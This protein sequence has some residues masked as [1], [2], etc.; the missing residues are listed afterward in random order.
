[1]STSSQAPKPDTSST[2]W[3][4]DRAP[5]PPG[6]APAS[7]NSLVLASAAFDKVLHGF[8]V[9]LHSMDGSGRMM[10]ANDF[11]L[12]T[13][14]YS[15]AEVVNKSFSE[16]LP[17]ESRS[18]LVTTIYPRYLVTGE[19]R[20]EEILMLRKDGTHVTV[21]LSMSAHRGEKG[22]LQRSVCMIEDITAR[23]IVELASARS[24]QRFRGAFDAAFHGMVLVSPSGMIEQGNSAAKQFLKRP[25]LEELS[26]TFDELL[27]KDD[28]AQ[29]LNGMRQLL[30]NEAPSLQQE[31]RYNLPDGKTVHGTTAVSLVKNE[32]GETEQLIIQIADITDKKTINERLHKAQKMEAIG[33]LTGGL[34]HDFN[35]LLTIII[36]NMQLLEGKFPNDEKSQKRVQEAIDA[37]R[38]GSDL[39]RQLLAFAKKQDLEPR[40]VG[41]NTLVKGMQALVERSIGENNELRVSLMPEEPH[42]L[43]DASQLE[44]AI[45]NLSNNARDAMP[46]GGRITIETQ[47]AYLDRFY[48]ERN[49]GVSPG[50]YVLVAVSDT[51]TGMS[52]ELLEKVFQPFFTTKAPGKGTG[53]GLSMVYGFIKQSGGHIAVYS[54]LG[55]GTSIKMYLPRRMRPGE[56]NGQIVPTT[57]APTIQTPT[58]A[59][60]AVMEQVPPPMPGAARKPKLLVVEDQEAVRAVACGFLEDFG[61]DIIEA[62]DGFEALAKLQENPDVDLMFSDVVM[63]GGMNGFDL[64]QAAQSMKASLKIVHTTGY[65]KGAMVHQDEPR[66]KE[67]FII[68]KPYRREDL[69]KMI[70]DALENQ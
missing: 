65:P 14:G 59:I 18:K 52:Q 55:H 36:G 13:M 69:Q 56:D 3:R 38:K 39:T 68:M 62:G 34:A 54:E 63:P 45:L 10:A 33:Q 49:P 12:Q 70:K 7:D 23:K 58:P 20:E 31:L 44:S 21:L 43:I 16:F 40:D 30:A 47:A 15:S 46:N 57:A 4:V 51:G 8:P 42:A 41:I 6:T 9:A 26:Q 2:G 11:W 35:N 50:H 1:M 24:D 64:A 48:A 66:F 60:T 27:H 67:G 19:C 61:Y 17:S 32:H 37:G 53:L 25:D 22:R 29:F 5:T 28:R